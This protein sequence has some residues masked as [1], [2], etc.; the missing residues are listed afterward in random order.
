MSNLLAIAAVPD[1]LRAFLLPFA[2]HFRAKGW[3]VDAMARGIPNC[4]ECLQA[5]NRVWDVDLARSPLDP[6]N[7]FLAPQQI[8][9]V[10]ARE[11]YDIVHVHMAVAAFVTRYA[12]KD[13]RK[14][15]IPKIIYTAHGL[16]FYR[17]GEPL[18]NTIFLMLE[19]LAGRWTDYLV[20]INRE[21]EKAAKRYRLLPPEKICY[22]PGI[23][24]D[25]QQY[26]PNAV[27]E[28]DILQV[29]Q[30]MGLAADTLLFL[31]IAEFIPRKRHQDILKAFA[32][33][34]RPNTCLAFAG[35]GPLQDQ[36]Q[37]LAS[38]LGVQDKVRFL[39][40]RRDIPT[41][42]RAAIATV[43]VSEQ[44][45]LPRSIMESLCMGVPAIG[46]AIRGTKD[47]LETGNGLLV[48]VGDTQALSQAFSWV[49][50]HPE[51]ARAM[52][53]QGCEQMYTYD[54]KKIIELHETL[55]ANALKQVLPVPVC[56]T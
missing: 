55:Y 31:S 6:Q 11:K 56:C 32:K 13:L 52:G 45:G 51:Q 30:E 53:N 35:E 42:I 28:A 54:L 5:F 7:L 26:N 39:G 38:E 12:L 23:G 29:R 9:E 17:G 37:Q 22:M 19:K 40:F 10:I 46:T 21:D 34:A 16:N 49:L 33:V 36:M 8:R 2:H 14:Q 4:T 15:G 18:H 27:S 48:P 20:V 25:L 24:V 43:V 1:S 50:D 44:E 41:L 47:L 3:R